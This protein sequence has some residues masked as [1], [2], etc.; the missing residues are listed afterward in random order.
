MSKYGPLSVKYVY[1]KKQEREN[2]HADVYIQAYVIFFFFSGG[3]PRSRNCFG[4]S[5]GGARN[6]ERDLFC[7]FLYYLYDHVLF[8]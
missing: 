6:G 2:M 1:E 3:K 8:I 7:L 5:N 4:R